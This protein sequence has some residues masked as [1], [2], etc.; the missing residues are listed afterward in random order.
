MS[1]RNRL[2][3]A[4]NMPDIATRFILAVIALDTGLSYGFGPDRWRAN[5]TFDAI[6]E[7]HI[8]AHHLSMRYYGF[9]LLIAVPLMLAC[10]STMVRMMGFII[11][12]SA[13]L[14]MALLVTIHLVRVHF[15][16]SV[17][18]SSVGIYGGL[19]AIYFL[20][21]YRVSFILGRSNV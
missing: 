3:E 8:G 17:S 4:G 21:A 12:G 15:G 10:Q 6:R 20:S 1:M 14:T 2:R 5:P 13:F 16:D 11:A 7:A 19:A 18:P 9:L